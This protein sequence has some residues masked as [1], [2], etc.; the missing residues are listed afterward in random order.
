[1]ENFVYVVKQPAE[2]ELQGVAQHQTVGFRDAVR[3]NRKPRFPDSKG[4]GWL[5]WGKDHR[6]YKKQKSK[7]EKP[8]AKK[9]EPLHLGMKE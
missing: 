4:R 7:Q 5:S 1:M 9:E 8:R 6:R 3:A 2:F